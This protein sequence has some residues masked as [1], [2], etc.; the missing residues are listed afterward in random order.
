M[1]RAK[2]SN[3]QA[4]FDTAIAAAVEDGSI[5]SPL[6][7]PAEQ[8]DSYWN[9]LLEDPEALKAAL[10]TTEFFP[11]L[12]AIPPALWE[13]RLIVYLYRTEPKIKNSGK[14]SD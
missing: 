5:I 4:V 7:V 8:R 14:S 10:A 1:A 13:K 11:L 6:A 2:K 3:S 12:H 9:G